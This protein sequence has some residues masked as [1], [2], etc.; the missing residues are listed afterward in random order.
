L[1]YWAFAVQFFEHHAVPPV[2]VRYAFSRCISWRILAIARHRRL[3]RLLRA[4][5]KR[6][7][8]A[9]PHVPP[10]KRRLVIKA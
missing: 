3:L 7:E 2:D 10:Q 6:D 9:S 1:V 8:L 4:A 5:E